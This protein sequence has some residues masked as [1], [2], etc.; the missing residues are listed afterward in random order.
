MLKQ[1][2][3]ETP[4]IENATNKASKKIK[5]EKVS[6]SEVDREETSP[7]NIDTQALT[8]KTEL[9][10]RDV[11]KGQEFI[12]HALRDLPTDE[13]WRQVRSDLN[14]VLK[15]DSVTQ[16]KVVVLG[17]TGVGKS[18]VLN[19]VLDEGNLLPSSGTGD[20]CT[21]VPIEI[22]FN[23]DPKYPDLKAQVQ[24]VTEAEWCDVIVQAKAEADA[25]E[26]EDVSRSALQRLH[27]VYPR[28]S[29]EDIIAS[30]VGEILATNDSAKLLGN[31]IDLQTKD[32]VSFYKDF[33]QQIG[34]LK[35]PGYATWPMID[36]AR[37]YV[38]HPLLENGLVL[39]DIPGMFETNRAR[40]ENAAAYLRR[41]SAVCIVAQAG[42]SSSDANQE[43]LFSRALN[44]I[45]FD[46]RLDSVLL[47]CTKSDEVVLEET[48]EELNVPETQELQTQLNRA[49][50]NCRRVQERIESIQQELQN[51]WKIADFRKKDADRWKNAQKR[52]ASDW[53]SFRVPKERLADGKFLKAEY[54]DSIWDQDDVVKKIA[55]LREEGIAAS[56]Q[57]KELKAQIAKKKTQLA[58]HEAS[59]EQLTTKIKQAIF[60]ARNEFVR[61][62]QVKIY[63]D[64]VRRYDRQ[65]SKAV[66]K[67]LDLVHS[68]G[69]QLHGAVDVKAR[70]FCVSALAYS[71]LSGLKKY[72]IKETAET[73][74]NT[75]KCADVVTNVA[76]T[77]IPA[78]SERLRHVALTERYHKLCKIELKLQ[79]ALGSLQSRLSPR[80]QQKGIDIDTAAQATQDFASNVNQFLQKF[81]SSSV[82]D[83]KLKALYKAE[84]A[85][86]VLQVKEDAT[87]RADVRVRQFAEHPSPESSTSKAL[88][89]AEFKA[90]VHPDRR[91][92]YVTKRILGNGTTLTIDFNETIARAVKFF[93]I[94]LAKTVLISSRGHLKQALESVRQHLQTYL[95]DLHSYFRLSA[96]T[97][98]V[99]LR[100]ITLAE[101]QLKR[102]KLDLKQT[103]QKS[104]R[105]VSGC[106]AEAAGPLAKDIERRM[107]P[108]YA[109]AYQVSGSGAR[110][111]MADELTRALGT[112]NV[113]ADSISAYDHRISKAL[114]DVLNEL[115]DEISTMANSIVADY[116]ASMGDRA[117]TTE[118]TGDVRLDRIRNQM[119]AYGYDGLKAEEAEVDIEAVS[120]KVE[121]T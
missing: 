83:A 14:D 71:H 79:I 108:A 49:K 55:D 29:D 18:S 23:D 4:T 11:K 85:D 92:F 10:Q 109:R 119:I 56:S 105:A 106:H 72:A 32:R 31:C 120:E 44:Q 5:L 103:F 90:A 82:A 75:S 8:S 12:H 16:C 35:K 70:V 61:D 97:A 39:V 81:T 93:M 89:P 38:R 99:T 13:N 95:D 80:L 76:D 9:L 19:A 117:Q 107:V 48:A 57:C 60:K 40:I 52:A 45:Q 69:I 43:S 20:A 50:V 100:R 98:G 25:D 3:M 112:G 53:D 115:S 91:G 34:S 24:Y 121:D 63:L 86:R 41:C 54:D 73:V 22:H 101:E 88:Y 62:Q 36:H 28:L 51:R 77:E 102:R 26:D 111:A 64:A 6:Q 114:D 59:A 87:K 21:A 27:T 96:I 74:R 116:N 17:A 78:L 94:A 118:S 7:D 104:S 2:S 30:S 113:I 15:Q 47:V 46:Q 84:F 110:A 66:E 58:T 67:L 65:S 37:L 33:K 68:G 42:R 1:F